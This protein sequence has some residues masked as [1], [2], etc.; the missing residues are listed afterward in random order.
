MTVKYNDEDIHL[1]FTAITF[2]PAKELRV[3]FPSHAPTFKVA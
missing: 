1:L 3:N 2:D